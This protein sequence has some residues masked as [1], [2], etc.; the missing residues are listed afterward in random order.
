MPIMLGY[1]LEAHGGENSVE[2][3]NVSTMPALNLMVDVHDMNTRLGGTGPRAIFPGQARERRSV[4]AF[5]LPPGIA[6][7]VVI[8]YYDVI[9]SGYRTRR[10][11]WLA[12]QSTTTIEVHDFRTGETKSLVA[13]QAPRRSATP[14]A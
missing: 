10:A 12:G 5:M 6:Y 9:G 7:E 2:I 14:R 8:T 11:S 1:Q 4:G 13:G 3:F